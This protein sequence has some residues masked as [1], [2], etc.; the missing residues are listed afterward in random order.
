MSNETTTETPP[1]APAVGAQVERL[2]RRYTPGPWHAT[3]RKGGDGMYRTEIYSTQ[4]GGIATCEWTPKNCGNGVTATYREA[5]ALLIAAAPDMANAL[6]SLLRHAERVN[7]VLAQECGVRFVDT[8]P[9]DMARD[10]L[11]LADGAA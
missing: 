11:R 1:A 9:L 10:A 6:R 7:E 2:V 4:Y 3:H 8:G 5:N